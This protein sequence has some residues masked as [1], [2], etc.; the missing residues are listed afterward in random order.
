MNGKHSLARPAH[1]EGWEAH[2][3][4][5]FSRCKFCPNSPVIWPNAC[6][7][8][9]RVHIFDTVMSINDASNYLLSFT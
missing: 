5:Y 7:K 2:I 6:A 3:V 9:M 8:L 4:K 1:T